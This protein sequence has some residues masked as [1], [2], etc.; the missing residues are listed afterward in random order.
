MNITP[1]NPSRRTFLHTTALAGGGLLVGFV[2][3]GCVRAGS[4]T[5]PTQSFKPNSFIRITPDNRITVIVSMAEM[6]Q[7]VL[8]SIPQ[9]VAEE[10][11]VDWQTLHFE[12]APVDP[13]YSNP[14]F[15]LQGTG[16]STSIKAFWEPMR[17][18]GAAAREMLITA[19]AETWRVDHSTCHAR[20]SAVHHASGKSLTYGQLAAKAAQV[21]APGKVKLKDP[22][23]FRLLGQPKL[24]L[25]SPS[26]IN[27]TAQ[28]GMDVKLPGL[29]TALIARAPVIG[30][31]VV[32]FDA[33]Q[34]KSM[35]GVR[36]VVQ[37]DA[38][39]AVVAEGYWAAKTARD[40]LTVHWGSSD[41]AGLS[42]DTLR[43]AMLK[44]LDEPGMVARNEGDI[45][46]LKPASTVEALYEAPYLAHACMEPMNCTASVSA[47]G[48][49]IWA[50]TQASGVNRAVVAK[51]TG[52]RPEQIIVHTTLLGGGFGRRFAQD[53]VVSAVLISKAIAAPVKLV[54]T[55][56]DDMKAQFYRPAA[57]VKLS[58][59]LDHDANPVSFTAK[60]VCSS[61]GQAAGFNKPGTLDPAAVEGLSDWPY[62]TANRHIEWMPY[63]PGIGVWFL[64]SVGN[65]QNGFFAE[66]FADE[67]AHAA[68][69][70]PYQYRRR[71]LTKHPRHLAVLELAAQKA[72]WGQALPQGRARGI[73]VLESFG[74]YVAEVVEVSLGT[75]GTPRVHRVVCAVDCGMTVNPGIV[76]RQMQSA[77]VFGLSA[78]LHGEITIK[79]GAVVQSNFNDYPV[80]RMSE[81]PPIEVHILASTAPPSGVGEPGTPPLAPALANALF[82][83]TGKRVR[84]LPLNA[85]DFKV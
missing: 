76:T 37:V 18:A 85:G 41:Q 63:E 38:G 62:D 33:A 43:A 2:I 15:G 51:V 64:R 42:S 3:P 24:R 84:R 31:Q 12:Q 71:L 29:L 32:S 48:V 22:K 60:A 75:D 23:D 77:I 68:G 27:G 39:V 82:A 25:D 66:S 44:R 28:F 21:P 61:V 16:G 78:A 11:E 79:D 50:P 49:E 40:A 26:K 52:F 34:T 1:L 80:V 67:L 45:A 10:L 14:A 65:S 81:A 8:T 73:A 56:E 57:L 53:F 30:A 83:L 7:G 69:Q 54:Y 17:Q 72:D 13:V 19:A 47:N 5:A 59:G 35:P 46:A 70:D 74:S 9:L 58:C 55:R 6:G 20:A 4:T 36:H